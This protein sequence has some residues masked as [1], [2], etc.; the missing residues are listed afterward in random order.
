MSNTAIHQLLSPNHVSSILGVSPGTLT[1]WRCTGRV[2]LPF[3]KVG[4][5]VMYRPEDIQ[6]F[7]NSQT[8]F[9]TG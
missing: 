8:L 2:G 7:I 5:K 6:N 1:V 4:R 3:V 9:H